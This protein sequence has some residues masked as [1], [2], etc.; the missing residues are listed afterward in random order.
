MKVQIT[1]IFIFLCNFKSFSQDSVNIHSMVA[2]D[3]YTSLQGT[4]NYIDIDSTTGGVSTTKILNHYGSLP[5]VYV[6]HPIRLMGLYSC[7]LSASIGYMPL[8][9]KRTQ[10]YSDSTYTSNDLYLNKGNTWDATIGLMRSNTRKK[11][12]FMYGPHLRYNYSRF[13]SLYKESTSTQLNAP[14]VPIRKDILTGYGPS[15]HAISIA[16][17]TI[18]TLQLYNHLHLGFRFRIAFYFEST[19]GTLLNDEKS[20]VNNVLKSTSNLQRKYSRFWQYGTSYEPSLMLL[21]KF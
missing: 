4:D 21:W 12:A 20:Y 7:H 19:T 18:T 1:I 13:Y 15:K 16:L 11:I 3:Y 6:L 17:N 14:N 10:V 5:S 8:V 9:Q 2:I